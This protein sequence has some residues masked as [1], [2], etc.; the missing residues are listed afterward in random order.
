[1]GGFYRIG[2]AIAT[3]KRHDFVEL[4]CNS[5]GDERAGYEGGRFRKIP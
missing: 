1:V 5:D 3:K 4:T 2:T